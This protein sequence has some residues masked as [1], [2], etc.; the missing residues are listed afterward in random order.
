MC[1][2][3]WPEVPAW[4][5]TQSGMVYGANGTEGVSSQTRALSLGA[6]RP[7]QGA[8]R[9]K[10]KSF[11]LPAEQQN[12]APS[13]WNHSHGHWTSQKGALVVRGQAVHALINL[14]YWLM[15]ILGQLS[16]HWM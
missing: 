1:D 10:W 11:R 6:W 13:H 14:I 8:T 3:G 9:M 16:V 2:I 7:Q 12:D 5:P 15:D 4:I